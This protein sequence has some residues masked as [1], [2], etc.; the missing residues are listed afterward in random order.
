MLKGRKTEINQIFMRFQCF[1]VLFPSHLPDPVRVAIAQLQ[2]ISIVCI[3][4]ETQIKLSSGRVWILAIPSLLQQFE[5][6][7]DCFND[8]FLCQILVLVRFLSHSCYL[9]Y[10][11]RICRL[12]RA[13][14]R[15]IE[16]QC[17]TKYLLK[18]SFKQ[19]PVSSVTVTLS[20]G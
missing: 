4:E 2:I 6:I 18:K 15:L 10:V 7:I 16:F 13:A 8:V 12:N 14:T 11:V 5:V 1:F 9:T 20:H 19:Y 17:S 3:F